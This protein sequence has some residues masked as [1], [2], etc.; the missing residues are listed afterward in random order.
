MELGRVLISLP[1]AFEPV[2][3]YTTELVGKC[4]ARPT[5]TFLP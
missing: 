5:V 4:D 1:K 3:G 2:G